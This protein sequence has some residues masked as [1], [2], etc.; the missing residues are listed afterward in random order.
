MGDINSDLKDIF[1]EFVNGGDSE[2]E[3]E[4]YNSAVTQYFKAIAVLCD[5]KIYEK[6]ATLPENHTERFKQ[7]KISFPKAYK[8]LSKIFNDYTDSYNIKLIKADAEEMKQN[9]N[10]IKRLL[11]D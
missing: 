1:D 9:V 6:R 4:R 8:E 2:L 10:K 7:L 3:K 11:E 5:L